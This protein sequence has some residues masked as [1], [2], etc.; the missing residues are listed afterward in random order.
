M[1]VLA[2]RAIVLSITRITN[3]GLMLISPVILVRLLPVAEFGRYREYLLYVSVLVAFATFSIYESQLYFIPAWLKHRWQVIR[4]TTVLVACSST[5]V[6]AATIIVD[7]LLKGSLV[8]KFVWPMALYVLL[9]VNVDFWEWAWVA[10][11]RAVPVLIYTSLRLVARMVVVIVAALLTHDVTTIIWSLIALE[12]VRLVG[13]FIAWRLAE[14]KNE[15]RAHHGLWREQLKFCV[16]S[17]L[18]VVL[19]MASRN[20]G[21]MAVVK[22][23][24]TA[25]LAWYTIGLYGEPIIAAIRSSI[26]AVLLPEMV[27]RNSGEASGQL[28]IWKSATVINCIALF[29]I[30]VLLVRFAKPLVV[31]VFGLP[32]VAAVPVLQIYTLV[33]VRECFDLTLPLRAV[34]RT[35]PLVR[36]GL[37]GL[38]VNVGCVA[39]LVRPY[40]IV[41]AVLA[42]VAAGLAEALYLSTQIARHTGY[43][44]RA[45][46]HWASIGKVAAAA[47]LAGAAM[48]S[49][50]WTRSLGLFGVV[51]AAIVYLM[52]FV[53]LLWMMRVPELRLLREWLARLW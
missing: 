49:D 4:Q 12:A 38:I 36:S 40:G 13:S 47:L 25:P 26:S 18:A 5:L 39:A 51:P 37:V 43:H 6:V 35:V 52:L 3:Y 11:N 44:V 22:W 53:I 15:P 17:G 23:L 28:E 50:F 41:G 2:G 48:L 30:C 46:V 21:G 29:P 33:I 1:T 9:Y 8:G 32:Y 7:L 20:V 45:L 34:N 24:G 19:G 16:P 42:M 31:G 27:R 14:D 10:G